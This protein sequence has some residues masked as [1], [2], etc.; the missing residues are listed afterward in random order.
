MLES[1]CCWEVLGDRC[2]TALVTG[3][4]NVRGKLTRAPVGGRDGA[5]NRHGTPLVAGW[6]LSS[7]NN[8]V[9]AGFL[10]CFRNQ[11]DNLHDAGCGRKFFVKRISSV[12]WS[13]VRPVDRLQRHVGTSVLC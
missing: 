5:T 8:D 7:L 13:E 4:A 10:F 6:I 1:R 9:G 2:R 12:R 3:W 11:V